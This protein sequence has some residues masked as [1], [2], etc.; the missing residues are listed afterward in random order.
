MQSQN[1]CC[2]RQFT[3]SICHRTFT[4]CRQIAALTFRKDRDP[5]AGVEDETDRETRTRRKRLRSRQILSPTFTYSII[6]CCAFDSVFFFF[7]SDNRHPALHLT[8]RRLFPL[9]IVPC[10]ALI[11]RCRVQQSYRIDCPI[12]TWTLFQGANNTAKS[13]PLSLLQ[14][15]S[16][17]R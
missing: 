2:H 10:W 17:L 1:R 14:G 4:P 5:A 16:W 12:T 6:P 7:P 9:F 13:R 11:G 3:I 15:K 8:H